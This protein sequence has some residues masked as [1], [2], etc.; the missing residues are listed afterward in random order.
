MS[1]F[2]AKAKLFACSNQRYASLCG[3]C[4]EGLTQLKCAVN[5]LCLEEHFNFLLILQSAFNCF[6]KKN[7]NA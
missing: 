3:N 1:N 5:Q 6:A 7:L 2:T 4:S